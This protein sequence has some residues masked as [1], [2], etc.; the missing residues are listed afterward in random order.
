MSAAR[1]GI[2]SDA[3][4]LAADA[5]AMVRT[6][7]ELIAI[8]VQEEKSRIARQVI[9]A[10]ATIFFLSFGLLLGI[11]WISFSLDEARRVMVIGILAVVF[12]AA[13]ALAAIRIAIESRRDRPFAATLSVLAED[14]RALGGQRG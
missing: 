8:E 4:G 3:R 7:L 9:Y 6:R 11:L 5:L 13:A 12:L 1:S 10:T 14:E 2:I